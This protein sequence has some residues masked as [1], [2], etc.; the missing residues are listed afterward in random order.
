[1]FIHSALFK[2]KPKE[3]CVYRRDSRMWASYA[4]KQKGFVA[5]FTMRRINEKNQYA[6]VYIWKNKRDNDRFMRKF[7]DWL[8]S[9]S[10]SKIKFLGY[11]NLTAMDQIR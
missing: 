10:K 8:A 9:K 1:M 3:V 11:Y 7:H 2:I 4:K 6:S 5:C